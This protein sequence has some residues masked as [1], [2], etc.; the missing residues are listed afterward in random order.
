MGKR[1][2]LGLAMTLACGALVLAGEERKAPS[3]A[4]GT[5][6]SATL[7]GDVIKW[8]I[9][10]GA[11]AGKKTYE[12]TAD[13]QVAYTEKDGVKQATSIRSAKG[14]EFKAKEGVTVA[15]GKFASAKVGDDGA[16]VT[17][18]PT[19]GDKALEVKLPKQVGVF[20]REGDD[21]KLLAMG[22]GVPRPPK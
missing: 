20:Y 12:M 16:V 4:T 8:E 6:V 10:L 14:R 13:V 18:T 21:G 9:D 19:E 3:Q 17:I 7:A 22:I 1:V 15:K 2:L 5:V 11:D